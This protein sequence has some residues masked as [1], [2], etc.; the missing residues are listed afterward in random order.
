[1]GNWFLTGVALLIGVLINFQNGNH[2]TKNHKN[3]DHMNSF[4]SI[5]EIPASDVSRAISFYQGI[6]DVAIEELAFPG[7]H[8]G[9]F[10][11]DDQMN[12]GVLIKGDDYVPSAQGVTIYL[13]AGENLQIILD[14]VEPNGGQ[15]L[16]PKTPHADESGFFALFLDSEGNRLGL[17]SPK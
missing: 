8:M 1:M 9:L 11:T 12:Y 16:V 5:F 17:H 7:M 4:V 3:S 14:R 15:I 13:N 6:L 2:K 10:P